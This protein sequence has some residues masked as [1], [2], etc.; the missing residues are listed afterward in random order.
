[1]I[2]I[3]RKLAYTS[4]LVTT[5]FVIIAFVVWSGPLVP[6]AIRALAPGNTHLI[7][8]SQSDTR[9]GTGQHAFD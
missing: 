2:E 1:M 4:R 5:V 6:E 7:E 3:K 9:S 8:L